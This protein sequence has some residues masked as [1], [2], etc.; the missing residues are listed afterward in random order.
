MPRR[1]P[2]QPKYTMPLLAD[3]KLYWKGLPGTDTVAY[4][5][6]SQVTLKWTIVNTATGS[7]ERLFHFI[8]E[9]VAWHKSSFK[10]ETRKHYIYLER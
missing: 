8:M 2:A 1:D 4:L 10:C 9:Q 6:Q 7:D 3:I 5:A